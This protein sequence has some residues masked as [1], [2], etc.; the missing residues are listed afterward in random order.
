MNE[1]KCKHS[2]ECREAYTDKCINCENNESPSFYHPKKLKLPPDI[3]LDSPPKIEPIG[4][5]GRF[6]KK[7][8]CK[9]FGHKPK[10]KPTAE[11]PKHINCRC[12]RCDS[13]LICGMVEPPQEWPRR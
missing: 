1:L 7:L 2:Q 5:D 10:S 6:I 4:F 8:L 3:L 13:E 9:I 12:S 11:S